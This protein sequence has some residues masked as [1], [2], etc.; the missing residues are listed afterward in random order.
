VD[1][2]IVAVVVAA[3]EALLT[4]QLGALGSADKGDA[5]AWRFSGRWFESNWSR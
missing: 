3:A 5:T 1:P 4:P 2:A